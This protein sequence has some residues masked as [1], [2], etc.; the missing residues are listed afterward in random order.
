VHKAVRRNIGKGKV[1]AVSN[2]LEVV[3][4]YI[5]KRGAAWQQPEGSQREG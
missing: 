2:G 1:Y 3:S 5:L 4:G